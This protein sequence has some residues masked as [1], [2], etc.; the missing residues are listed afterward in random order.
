MNAALA[1]IVEST[2]EFLFPLANASVSV[3]RLREGRRLLMSANETLHLS[4]IPSRAR[5]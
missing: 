4:A 2:H 5:R 1:A 3:L